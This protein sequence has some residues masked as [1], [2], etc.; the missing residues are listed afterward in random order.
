VSRRPAPLLRLRLAAGLY[1]F[2]ESLFLL[3]AI[4]VL[5][6]IALAEA[7][8]ALDDIADTSGPVPFTVDVSGSAAA[9]MLSTIARR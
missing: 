5:A 3:P 6:G 1:R 8:A 4:V 9:S 2:R 7:A